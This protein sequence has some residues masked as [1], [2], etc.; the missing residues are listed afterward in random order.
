[1]NTL[2]T[3]GIFLSFFLSLLLA[4]KKQKSVSD[5]ILAAWM[6]II[7]IHL[8][9]YYLYS[10][11]YWTKYP[12]LVGVTLPVP[13]LHGPMLYL[14]TLY[15]LREDTRL[16]EIDLLHFTPA[17]FSYL[18]MSRF[19]FFYSAEQKVL[20]DT[21]QINDFSLFSTLCLIAF[22]FS[23]IIY[24]ILSFMLLGK[25]KSLL[26]DNFSY[27]RKIS[28]D[29][30][31]YCIW[32]IGAIYLTAAIVSVLREGLGITFPFNADF[33]FYAMIITFVFCIGYF[34]IRHQGLFSDVS[35]ET[36]NQ[37]VQAKQKKGYKKS[38]LKSDVAE[39]AH[40]QLQHIMQEEKLYTNPTLTLSDLAR[41]VKVTPNHLSQIINQYEQKNF[42]DFVNMYRIEE[43][44]QQAS[45]NKNFSLL[46]LA[47]DAGFNSKSS[48]N[49]V[50][51]KHKGLTPSKYM[52]TIANQ[53]A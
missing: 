41:R 7:G 10:L 23:G 29:W 52:T 8:S 47:F 3:I 4:R 39:K 17:A 9:S 31:K 24:P 33:I 49:S 36:P 18:Y 42:H 53:T 12:H 40:Q 48:F 11:G 43:F 19:Y 1:M 21:G 15:S 25:Y 2:F 34:G 16:R 5:K 35:G 6:F 44:I 26:V 46:A 51:K 30:L 13:L 50:F 37:I 20:V 28:L 45:H 22:L 32:G 27:D 38:G 14:Y